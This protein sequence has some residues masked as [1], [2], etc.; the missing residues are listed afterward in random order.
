M[1]KLVLT[2]GVFVALFASAEEPYLA[3][4]LA[5]WLRADLGLTTNAVGGV[6]AWANQGTTG[7]AA[8]VSPHA[9]NSA[10]HVA[11]EESGIGGKP[12]LAFDGGIYLKTT[13][14]LDLGIASDGGGAWFVVLKTPCTSAERANMGIMGMVPSDNT[15]FGAFFA[16]NGTENYKSS[17]H[18]D[19]GEIAFSSN[20]V[21]IISAMRWTDE[22]GTHAYPMNL[23]TVGGLVTP[24]EPGSAVFTVG[25]FADWSST[26]K[27]EIAE[28]RIY[29]RP[30]TWRERS[31]VQFEL[32]A[33]YGVHWE[34]HGGIDDNAI[35]WYDESEQ[36]GNIS[37]QGAPDE[38]VSRVSS[39]GAT[40]ELGTPSAA[41]ER[42]GYFSS[43]GGDGVSRIWFVSTWMGIR[44]GSNM[45]LT[46]DKS[47]VR[48]GA[49]PTLYYAQSQVYIFLA[50][51]KL[52]GV[53]ATE[54]D[55]SVSF[56]LPAGN[57]W[58]GFYCVRGDLD[59]NLGVWYRA[60]MG[61]KTNEVGGVTSWRNSGTYGSYF[62]MLPQ[63]DNSAAHI[64]YSAEGMG[65]K[66]TI[67][68]DGTDGAYLKSADSGT[69]GI[70]TAGSA[71]FVVC[72]TAVDKNNRGNMV[73]FGCTPGQRYGCFFSNNGDSSQGMLRGYIFNGNAAVDAP[74]LEEGKP[75]VFS[76]LHWTADGNH[77]RG[78]MNGSSYGGNG[79]M[80]APTV[81]DDRVCIGG[82]MGLT[83]TKVFNGDI[84]ELR[85]YNRA[86]TARERSEVQFELCSRY[87]VSWSGHG[88][89]DDEALGW[90]ENGAQ[91]GYNPQIGQ[92]EAIATTATA[93]GAT[94]SLGAAPA[95]NVDS[96]GYLTHNGSNSF[97][98][99]WYVSAADAARQQPMTFSVNTAAF[100]KNWLKLYRSASPSGPWSR[101]GECKEAVDGQCVFTFAANAWENGYYQIVKPTMGF[102]IIIK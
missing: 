33:R 60:D 69:M 93:G 94:L 34:S 32:C 47:K 1:K 46:F 50:P 71:W 84:A 43:N 40:L 88:G 18:G 48:V 91:F 59:S 51:T 3:E 17:F 37:N 66:P 42:I 72:K 97:D 30:L 2:I 79:N 75:Q 22:G 90:C 21:Q 10:G 62:E 13:S 12:S 96:Q 20:A 31:R 78:I 65:G 19:I 4:S 70:T 85:I 76:M 86:L 7:S 15:R 89:V 24:N 68:F 54:T 36:L 14:A 81:Q 64:A 52:T 57:W 55:D 73:L 44:T 82:S 6:T 25:N 61:L 53:T 95:A 16:N 39:C 58:N 101:I 74:Q 56:T 63:I 49:N 67:T 29:N 35:S 100:G 77:Y 5:V 23:W 98:R 83:W 45:T 11:Y 92:P 27:G 99:V 26:F 87:G 28:I 38:L 102:H 41:D 9:D 80:T 8:D